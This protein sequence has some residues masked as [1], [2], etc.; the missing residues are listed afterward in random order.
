MNIITALLNNVC[1]S[2]M[3]GVECRR[4]VRANEGQWKS[5]L[6][7]SHRTVGGRKQLSALHR[8]NICAHTNAE[9]VKQVVA[10]LELMR[11][12]LST[13]LTAFVCRSNDTTPM[14][15]EA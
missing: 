3:F 15:T 10:V 1:I 12:S 6:G 2:R 8:L 9:H 14:L 7:G 5:A 13:A 11:S 4:S